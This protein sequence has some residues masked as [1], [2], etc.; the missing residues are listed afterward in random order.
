VRQR[1]VNEFEVALRE[2]I[3]RLDLVHGQRQCVL[4]AETKAGMGTNL[5]PGC[6]RRGW[7]GLY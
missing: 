7:H 5:Q 3:P 1:A 2:A 4:G 6:L